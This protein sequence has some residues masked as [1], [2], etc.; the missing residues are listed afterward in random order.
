MIH[1]R[2]HKFELHSFNEKQADGLKVQTANF[3][4][5]PIPRLNISLDLSARYA[6]MQKSEHTF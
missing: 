5:F 3:T 2:S 6:Q 1:D 4:Q